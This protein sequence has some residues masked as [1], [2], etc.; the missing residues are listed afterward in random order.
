ME[1]KKMVIWEWILCVYS[2]LGACFFLVYS[3]KINWFNSPLSGRK[4]VVCDYLIAV[5][6]G[7][8]AWVLGPLM[9]FVAWV[10]SI[11]EQFSVWVKN[12][13]PWGK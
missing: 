10:D 8:G 3:T 6:C 11:S 7:P 12:N 9:L 4:A 13:C 1:G 5:V 2:V